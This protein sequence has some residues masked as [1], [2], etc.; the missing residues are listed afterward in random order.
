M[1]DVQP[2]LDS[3]DSSSSAS[4]SL[5]P[6]GVL[7]LLG[8]SVSGVTLSLGAKNAAGGRHDPYLKAPG[9]LLLAASVLGIGYLFVSGVLAESGAS[10]AAEAAEVIMRL[11]SVVA[12]M[13]FL[14]VVIPGIEIYLHPA[15]H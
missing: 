11:P 4:D 5:V 7:A 14:A 13:V 9:V 8:A 15:N 3:S 2:P 10:S 6:L 12:L 1:A